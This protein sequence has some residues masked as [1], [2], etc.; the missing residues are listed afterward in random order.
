MRTAVLCLLLLFPFS[1]AGSHAAQNKPSPPWKTPGWLGF[2]YELHHDVRK[3]VKTWLYVRRVVTGGPADRAGVRP[4]DVIVK[5]N[6]KGIAF[7]SDTAALD[8]F[9][10]R[11]EGEKIVF[12][13]LRA[14]GPI[15]L[16]VTAG[17]RP[18][19]TDAAWKDNYERAAKED[20]STK[21]K[22]G[23]PRKPPR[24]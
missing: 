2:G 20:Q 11:K 10:S 23:A 1:G 15:S 21:T 8:F 6:G 19:G 14:S 5:V 9:A 18:A 4:Q 24:N 16:T 3:T 13:I 12:T 7:A 22:A 17:N